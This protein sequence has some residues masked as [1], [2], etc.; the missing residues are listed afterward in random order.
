[1]VAYMN[2][3][4]GELYHYLLIQNKSLELPAYQVKILH[5]KIAKI[6]TGEKESTQHLQN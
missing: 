5:L 1:M 3:P 6:L 4:V 2:I